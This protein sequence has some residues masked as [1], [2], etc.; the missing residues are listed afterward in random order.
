[1]ER[2]T[3]VVG[4]LYEGERPLLGTGLLGLA[5]GGVSFAGMAFHGPI[6]EPEGSLYKAATFDIAVGLFLLTLALIVQAAGFTPRGR[7]AWRWILIGLTLFGYG[8]E[9]I[10]IFRGFDPR[11]SRVSSPLDQAFGGLFFLSAIG[12]MICFLVLMARFFLRPAEG[13]S[14]PLVVA[15]RYG[16]VASTLAFAVGIAMSFH[17]GPRV[18]PGGNLLPLH[19]AG[20][21]GLQSIPL[22]ALL[23]SWAGAEERAARKAVHVAGLA[24]LGACA[25][26]ARQSGSGRFLLEPSPASALAVSFL[27][28]WAV[29]LGRAV[30]SFLRHGAW[31]ESLDAA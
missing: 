4:K 26:I 31:P 22:V 17:G 23:F 7:A 18:G 20:F 6:V 21:H 19:A 13:P 24:W 1:M 15:L 30:K 10:Q 16:A 2:I 27:A 11:F 12:I 9:T 29:V 3:R 25:A 8:V 14:G 5:L 28:V